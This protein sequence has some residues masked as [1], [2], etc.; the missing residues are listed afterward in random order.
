LNAQEKKFYSRKEEGMYKLVFF[1]DYKEQSA[2]SWF[3]KDP[4]KIKSELNKNINE[5]KP[6]E[7][8]DLENAQSM[9]YRENPP[10]R[11][12]RYGEITTHDERVIRIHFQNDEEQRLWRKVF[13]TIQKTKV[14]PDVSVK[15]EYYMT[16]IRQKIWICC[17]RWILLCHK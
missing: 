3:N 14:R 10:D 8:F 6:I 16:H 2:N 12:M 1:S 5:N 17:Q 11:D 7:T 15:L 9:G 4:S 13:N